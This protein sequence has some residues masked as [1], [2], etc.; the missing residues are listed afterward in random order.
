MITQALQFLVDTLLGLATLAFLLRFYLQYMAAPFHNPFSQ[1]IVSLTNFAVRPVRKVVP[2][3]GRLDSSTF[4]LAFITQIIMQTAT[5]WLH[6][7]PLLVADGEAY[8]ALLG[9]ALVGLVKYSI[10]IFLYAVLLQAILS[11][12]NPYTPM[13]PVLD[14][15]TRPLLH[16]L[17]GIMPKAGAIDLT[18]LVLFILAELL[19]MLLVAPLEHAL[20]RSF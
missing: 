18:P 3:F 20:L 15:L 11:W 2:A 1:A 6:D 5:L 12:V 9:L 7:F 17:R 14:S 10:Y 8:L 4:L 19:L 13:A 16:P